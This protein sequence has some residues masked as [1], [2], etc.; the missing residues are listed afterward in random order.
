VKTIAALLLALLPFSAVAGEPADPLVAEAVGKQV[1]VFAEFVS[2]TCPACREMAPIVEAALGRHRG[3]VHQVH[4]ADRELA[5]SEKYKVRCV[6]VYVVVD[7]KGEVKFND[8]GTHSDE[9]LD[10]ILKAAGVRRR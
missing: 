7:P 3:V 5:L 8:V 4:D 6:P 10:E 2:R 1:Y 9:E